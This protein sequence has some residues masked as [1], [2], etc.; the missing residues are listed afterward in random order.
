VKS[1]RP[2][3]LAEIQ[4]SGKLEDAVKAKLDAALDAFAG[5]FQPSKRAGAA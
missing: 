3:I 2:E 1:Q 4:S 5:V